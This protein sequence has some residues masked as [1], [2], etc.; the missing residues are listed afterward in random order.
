[1]YMKWMCEGIQALAH[2]EMSEDNMMESLPPHLS[3]FQGKTQAVSL[4]QQALLPDIAS[5]QP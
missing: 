5:H 4:I 2:M 3:G 1:M